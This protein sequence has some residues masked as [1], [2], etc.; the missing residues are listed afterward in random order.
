MTDSAAVPPELD[1]G[2]A[3]SAGDRKPPFVGLTGG[4]AAGKSTALEALGRLGAATLSTDQIVHDIY[5][6]DD[7][8]KLVEE[9]LGTEVISDGVVDRDAVARRVFNDPEAREWLE[10]MIWP[11]VGERMWE[12]RQLQ[13]ACDPRPRALV[14]EVPLLFEAG[15]GAAFDETIAVTVHDDLRRQRA[16]TRGHEELDGRDA[17][18][19]TQSEK[20]AQADFEVVNDGS[21]EQLQSRLNDV[22]GL[23]EGAHR[24]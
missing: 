16:T 23:I 1:G 7:V 15:M 14:V 11:R 18:Q 2:T 5:L 19:L 21:I 12:W 22:L 13:E 4:V 6:Q 10:Q 24:A 9:R 3:A 17:R 20:A 8:L